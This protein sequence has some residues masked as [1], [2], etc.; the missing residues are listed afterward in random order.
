M[1]RYQDNYN[2]DD[3]PFLSRLL[4][5]CGDVNECRD[6]DIQQTRRAK[7]YFPIYRSLCK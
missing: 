1:L 4:K 7:T 3:N 6:R 2:G 5:K